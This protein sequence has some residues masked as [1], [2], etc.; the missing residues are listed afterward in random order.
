VPKLDW[1]AIG[2]E[3]VEGIAG[4]DGQI[5]FPTLR[6][7]ADRH[8]LT[9]GRVRKVAAVQRWTEQRRQFIA[10]QQQ[11]HA[12]ARAKALAG[13]AAE[14]DLLA[15]DAARKA[16]EVALKRLANCKDSEAKPLFEALRIA[17]QV[18]RVALGLPA[19]AVPALTV[20]QA[21]SLGQPAPAPER[22]TLVIDH[23]DYP[24]DFD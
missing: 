13:A 18:G 5:R 23:P 21:V 16:V 1:S 3:Y 10:T 6:E 15:L 4:S 24:Q 2:R 8:G 14:F 20:Q 9:W 22:I 7:V 19:D 11:E 17:Q 12:A